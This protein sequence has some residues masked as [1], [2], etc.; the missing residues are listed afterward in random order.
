ML[1]I[2]SSDAP[3]NEGMPLVPPPLQKVTF[4]TSQ[5]RPESTAA[6]LSRKRL[7]LSQEQEVSV[8]PP[9]PV[10]S[11]QV[12]ADAPVK[13][14]R[15]GLFIQHTKVPN[16]D[17]H[18]YYCY[19]YAQPRATASVVLDFE[20]SQF[21]VLGCGVSGQAFV[22]VDGTTVLK[23]F[24]HDH[25][26][27]H[28]W[29]VIWHVLKLAPQYCAGPADLFFAAP[30]LFD[31]PSYVIRLINAGPTVHTRIRQAKLTLEETCFDCCNPSISRSSWGYGFKWQTCT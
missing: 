15:R 11:N 25:E 30:P 13:R 4:H 23:Q 14:M 26:A 16:D 12:T 24:Y 19:K 17:E 7:P 5:G 20:R 28:E 21:K 2:A 6:R 1:H 9:L 27:L 8:L 3:F 22:S 31:E 18:D 29:R 10:S